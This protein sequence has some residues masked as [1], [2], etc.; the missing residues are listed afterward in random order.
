LPYASPTVTLFEPLDEG[1]LVAF[2]SERSGGGEAAKAVA[3]LDP[4]Q[5]FWI[6]EER[7]WWIA[8]DAI[9]RVARRVPA[10][11]EVLAA[12]H[13]RPIN[14]ADYAT[15]GSRWKTWTHLRQRFMPPRVREACARLSL[16]GDVTPA[17]VQGARRRLARNFHPDAGGANDEMAQINAA[18]DTVMEWLSQPR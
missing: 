18:A 5:R 4:W 12:W 8:D 7:A 13:Q 1:F 2:G 15:L 16:S 6:P 17:L 14:I 10:L 11:A 3:A 9:S